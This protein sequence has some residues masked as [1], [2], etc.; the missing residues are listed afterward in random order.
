MKKLI[1][2]FVG[3]ISL[4]IL[5]TQAVEEIIITGDPYQYTA[6]VFS[7]TYSNDS[8][9]SQYRGPASGGGYKDAAIAQAK[10]ICVTEFAARQKAV[11]NDRATAIYNTSITYCDNLGMGGTIGAAAGGLSVAGAGAVAFVGGPVGWVV[12]L[13]VG[14]SAVGGG[15]LIVQQYGNYSCRDQANRDFQYNTQACINY[16]N[17]LISDFCSK[18]Q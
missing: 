12:G 10:K 16:G 9:S 1:F 2:C 11:C 13:A 17:K 8:A 14:G 5:S 7:T 6:P 3:F 18:I 4:F 15:G